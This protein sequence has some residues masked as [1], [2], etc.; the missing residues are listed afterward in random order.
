MTVWAVL[1]SGP[2]MSPEVAEQVRGRCHVM[3]VSDSYRLAP[4]ADALA[5]TDAAWWRAHPGALQFEG[6]KFTG[7]P[8]FQAIDGVE[9]VPGALPGSNSGLL[10]MMAARH[11]GATAVLLCGYDL[12]GTH[13][14]GPHAAPLRNTTPDR[15]D[16]FRRQF[17]MWQP[18]DLRIWNCTPNSGLRCYAFADLETMLQ[19]STT[20]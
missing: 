9:R 4:W 7:A 2:S 12:H 19:E 3:A 8:S 1:A 10:G 5:S 17:A 18:K 6:R 14:F 16:A 11:L 20:C 15:F 13:F